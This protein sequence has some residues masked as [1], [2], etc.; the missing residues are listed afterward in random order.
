[1]S[2]RGAPQT[3]KRVS[4]A[5]S[6]RARRRR[7][8]KERDAERRR[9]VIARYGQE[10]YS[11]CAKKRRYA[12]E[13]AASMAAAHCEHERGEPLRYYKCRYCGG[14]HLTHTA[15]GEWGADGQGR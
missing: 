15:K 1:M 14:Y 4:A 3:P 11:S 10:A 8:A 2:G 6:R 5:R 13:T 9:Q 7:R 12:S